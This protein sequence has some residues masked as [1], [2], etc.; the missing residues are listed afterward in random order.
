MPNPSSFR[1]TPLMVAV[2]ALLSAPGVLAD[3]L[4]AT[5]PAG[6]GF[7]IKNA[8]GSQ[9]RFRVQEDGRV[10]VP[11]VGNGPAGSTVLCADGAGELGPC[12]PGVGD[13]ATG[14]T[15]PTGP[16]GAT[17]PTG[18]MG[19]TGPTG[20]TGSTGA[21]GPAG[22]AGATGAMGPVG[23]PGAP[24]VTGPTGS[25]GAAG[26]TGAT[27]PTGP[28]GPSGGFST[29]QVVTESS[30]VSGGIESLQASCP[31]SS[32][33]VVGGGCGAT[34]PGDLALARSYPVDAATDGWAC[35]VEVYNSTVFTAYAIC[36]E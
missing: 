13:G 27:G 31:S 10:L 30:N 21:T 24:G 16:T 20:V 6:G 17:G 25:N 34:N 26:P 9:E 33:Q 28:T 3:D 22:A 29:V 23:P 36:V 8:D 32:Y 15:G 2:G 1:K 14:P 5:V 11:E 4:S 18:D 12:A 7:V 19:A 35:S